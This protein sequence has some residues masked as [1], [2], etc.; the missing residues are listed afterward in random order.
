[1]KAAELQVKQAEIDLENRKLDLEERRSQQEDDARAVEHALKAQGAEF[2]QRQAQAEGDTMAGVQKRL[3][4]AV[5]QLAEVKKLA[6][7]PRK[8]TLETGPDGRVIGA[9]QELAEA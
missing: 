1:M 4:D 5:T 3:D 2:E 7:Q 8:L 6:T 9:K